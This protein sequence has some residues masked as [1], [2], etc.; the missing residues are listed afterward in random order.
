MG[1]ADFLSLSLKLPILG[2]NHVLIKNE[3]GNCLFFP[4]I[5]WR[6]TFNRSTESFCSSWWVLE[7]FQ[8][9]MIA[10]VFRERK[11]EGGESFLYR[12]VN[13][14][15][16]SIWVHSHIQANDNGWKIKATVTVENGSAGH[17][18]RGGEGPMEVLGRWTILAGVW[19]DWTTSK[20][21]LFGT[22]MKDSSLLVIKFPS[23]SYRYEICPIFSIHRTYAMNDNLQLTLS[24]WSPPETNL[25]KGE[26]Y[27]LILFY[28]YIRQSKPRGFIFL[29]KLKSVFLEWSN[30]IL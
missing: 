3:T 25:V 23:I 2:W 13:E 8:I 24:R 30:A 26:C 9:F 11:R 14:R 28:C 5:W 6:Y 17:E 4:E 1:S 22:D 10:L 7:Y 12:K 16:E 29:L 18:Q 15:I 19:W 20:D 21:D 27:L